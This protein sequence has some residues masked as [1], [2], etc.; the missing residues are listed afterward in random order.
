M[1]SN[2]NYEKKYLKYKNKYL[3]LKNQYSN[4]LSGGECY[5]L[6]DY[7]DE[8]V[9]TMENLFYLRSS[10]R[11]SIQNRCYAVRSLYRWIITQNKNM[12]PGTTIFITPLER[13]RLIQ[14]YQGLNNP[15]IT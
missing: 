2:L 12:L 7:D 3:I 13:Q 11:I 1:F 10:E 8:D 5:P 6:P 4:I 9:I 15:P 14:A